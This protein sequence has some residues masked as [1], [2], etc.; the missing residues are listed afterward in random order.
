MLLDSVSSKSNQTNVGR[1]KI[2]EDFDSKP[3]EP[4]KCEVWME[5]I[6]R[7]ARFYQRPKK[8]SGISGGQSW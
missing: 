5:K 8:L 4:V 6:Q 7:R 2:V 1:V 3:H